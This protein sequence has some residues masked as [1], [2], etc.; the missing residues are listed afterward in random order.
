[1]SLYYL[2]DQYSNRILFIVYVSPIPS[3]R[4]GELFRGDD[5]SWGPCLAGGYTYVVCT[6]SQRPGFGFDERTPRAVFTGSVQRGAAPGLKPLKNSLLQL[7]VLL[8]A[9]SNWQTSTAKRSLM[10]LLRRLLCASLAVKL[11][12]VQ[13]RLEL[14][15]CIACGCL[16][17]TYL[18]GPSATIT[19]VAEPSWSRALHALRRQSRLAAL[20]VPL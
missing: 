13:C 18:G 9:G 7:Q 5:C 16:L 20:S 17:H 3:F 19:Q 2:Y 4:I 10:L 8:P 14:Q 15:A 6:V 1:M 12:A 11:A